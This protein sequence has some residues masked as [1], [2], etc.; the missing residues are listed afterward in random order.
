LVRRSTKF[1]SLQN[2]Q[3][4]RR[5]L[6]QRKHR[7]IHKSGNS[8]NNVFKLRTK[9]RNQQQQ[10]ADE[11]DLP[12]TDEEDAVEDDLPVTVEEDYTS[13]HPA[14][15]PESTLNNEEDLHYTLL[16]DDFN[17]YCEDIGILNHLQQV[18]NTKQLKTNTVESNAKD[19]EKR[20]TI[21]LNRV[22]TFLEQSL[23]FIVSWTVEDVADA[24][25]LSPYN[26]SVEGLFV[27]VMK[28]FNYF[29]LKQ[30]DYLNML[31]RAPT[32]VKQVLEDYEE[33]F[34]K[35]FLLS[36]A[37]SPIIPEATV[38]NISSLLIYTNLFNYLLLLLICMSILLQQKLSLLMSKNA[39]I[40]ARQKKMN[41]TKIVNAEF[42]RKKTVQD[43][44]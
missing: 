44:V 32:T 26:H 35:Y 2:L 38:S 15:N 34:L 11:D 22:F 30:L 29:L 10:H 25:N 14:N 21:A 37:V 33:I 12:V 19:A 17:A 43:Y 36:E 16:K 28:N 41:R 1:D 42:Q 20:A 31:N 40:L 4:I 5:V 18:F 23:F 24:T 3:M 7:K 6:F 8:I 9:I 27:H 39:A 13:V